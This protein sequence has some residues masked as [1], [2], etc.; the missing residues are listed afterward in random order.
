MNLAY[1]L[2]STDEKG[3]LLY[4]V[5][6][7]RAVQGIQAAYESVDTH[8]ALHTD[9]ADCYPSLNRGLALGALYEQ[10]KLSHTWH[11]ADFAFGSP[12]QI[13]VRQD[14]K[15]I[16]TSVSDG[17][18]PQGHVLSSLVCGVSLQE[19]YKLAAAEHD[20]ITAKAVMD[21]FTAVGP[22]EGIK[23]CFA[24]LSAELGRVGAS[25]SLAKTVLQVHDDPTEDML[26]WAAQ[27]GIHIKKGNVESVGAMIGLDDDESIAFVQGK[28]AAYEPLLRALADPLLPIAL[29][30]YYA[31]VCALP[32]PMYLL[33]VMP[34]HITL[35]LMSEFDTKLRSVITSRL[36]IPS[37]LPH[38]A[39]FSFSQPMKESGVGLVPMELIAASARWSGIVVGACETEFLV[40][41]GLDTPLIRDRKFTFDTLVDAKVP[42]TAM[43]HFDCDTSSDHWMTL[44]ASPAFVLSHY[45]DANG[46][47]MRHVQH[48][49]SSDLHK[50]VRAQFLRA[51]DPHTSTRVASCKIRGASA[52]LTHVSA[53]L[54]MSDRE[55]EFALRLRC[56]LPPSSSPPSFPVCPLCRTDIQSD[57]FHFFSCPKLKRRSLN[58]RHDAVQ[59]GLARYARSNSCIVSI[60]PKRADSKV[61]DLRVVMASGA[62]QVDVSGTHPLAPSIEGKVHGVAGHALV[63][64]ENSKTSKYKDFAESQGDTF[65]PFAIESYG[66]LGEKALDLVKAISEEGAC[67]DAQSYRF[68]KQQFMAWLSVTWQR[69]NYWAFTEWSRL[70]QSA[71]RG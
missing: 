57:V 71:R 54:S 59:N 46:T 26:L 29:A 5:G 3:I 2:L 30:L 50:H 45:R 28:L 47:T 10:E 18:L 70:C 32:K 33:R 48:R 19:P 62:V 16:H 58:R 56:G 61:P 41:H 69:H 38:T 4:V 22:F 20:D 39:L 14:G 35:P 66:G 68:S 17:G 8:V 44:P 21:D 36:D 37:S 11:I 34:L 49:V 43:L 65:S 6:P 15:I 51:S 55:F 12:S 52:W 40:E 9:V 53:A 7:E 23:L 25:V 63:M 13:L 27:Q 24:R 67:I 31:R 60:T 1:I 64:R 42:V